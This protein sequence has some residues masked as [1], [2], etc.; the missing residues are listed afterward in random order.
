MRLLRITLALM[1][2]LVPL[3]ISGFSMTDRSAQAAPASTIHISAFYPI[4]KAAYQAWTTKSSAPARTPAF[5]DGETDVGYYINYDD[6]VSHKTTYQVVMYDQTGAPYITGNIHKFSYTGGAVVN[7]FGGGDPF[8]NGAYRMDLLVNGVVSASSTFTVGATTGSAT[9][10]STDRSIGERV[11]TFSAITVAAYKAWTTKSPAPTPTRAFPKGTVDIGYYI[12]YQDMNTKSAWFQVVIYDHT[13]GAYVTGSKH[14]FPYAKGD[15]LSYF[16]GG[17][18]F[19][20]GTYRMDL[21]V[22]N[23]VVDSVTFTVGA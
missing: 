4:T 13:G 18:P 22:Q 19:D 8:D 17:T 23:I 12:D 7:Y 2:T 21:I 16:G 1:L 15:Q 3:L 10:I 5:P 9:R 6:V 14:Q 20:A 11:N